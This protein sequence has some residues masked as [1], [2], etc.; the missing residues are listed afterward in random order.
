[1]STIAHALVSALSMAFAMGWEILWPLILGF[2]LSG[3]VQAVVT[4]GEMSRLLP[5]SSPRS[6]CI[7][8]GLGIASSSCSYAAVALARSIFR[9]GADFVAAMA[10]QFAST[11]LVIELGIILAVLIGWQFVAAEFAGGFIMIVMLTVMLRAV[12]TQQ[13]IA[14]AKQQ[15]DRGLMGR[16]EGHAAMDMSVSGEGSILARVVSPKGFTAISHYFVT[17]WA[18]IWIDIAVGL[19]IAGALAAWVPK[20]FWQA[21][22]LSADPVWSKIVGPLIGPIVAIVS[23]VCSVGNVPLAAVLWNGGISFGGVI[24]FLFADL[25]VL[26]ILDIYRRYYGLRIALLLLGVSYVAMA[27]AAYVIEVVFGIAGFVPQQRSA[28][29]VEAHITGNYTTWLNIVFLSF[30]ALLVW[31]FLKTGGPE[32]LRMM[33]KSVPAEAHQHS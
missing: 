12:M 28:Q 11:N 29:I 1:M 14:E 5:D 10:F 18:M 9:K 25:I 17:D 8:S 24:A 32:M 3:V 6:I 22:F 13:R 27:G 7:A 30:A 2:A 21:F 23:F 26:P 20:E 19:L 16:M 4:K 33:N 15:A 31:R